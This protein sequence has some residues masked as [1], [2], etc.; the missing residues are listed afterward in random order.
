MRFYPK[1]K[2][3]TPENFDLV[4]SQPFPA[5]MDQAID[6]LKNSTKIFGKMHIKL[7]PKVSRE[8]ICIREYTRG[9]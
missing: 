8:N 5:P 2:N 6:D 3:D 7:L 4:Y 1:Q 9:C